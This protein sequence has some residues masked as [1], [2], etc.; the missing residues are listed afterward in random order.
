MGILTNA[1][2]LDTLTFNDWSIGFKSKEPYAPK[3][4]PLLE[5]VVLE[6]SLLLFVVCLKTQLLCII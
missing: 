2:R 5:P 3:F 6:R 1:I 4:I